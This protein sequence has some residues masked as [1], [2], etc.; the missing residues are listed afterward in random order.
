M[1]RSLAPGVH[2]VVVRSGWGTATG[3][4]SVGDGGTRYRT[5]YVSSRADP[6]VI[7]ISESDQPAVIG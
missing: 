1:P 2:E 3:T 5:V 4:V 6:P 7:R